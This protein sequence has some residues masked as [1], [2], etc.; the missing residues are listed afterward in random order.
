MSTDLIAL[1]PDPLWNILLRF[2]ITLVVLFIV[3]RLIYFRYS[4]NEGNVFSFFLMGVMIFLVCV[5]LK[6]V[7]IQ[8]GMAL[9]LFA[10]FSI[11]RFRSRNLSLRAMTYFFT[12]IGVSVINSMAT[13]PKPVR[14]TIL[15]NSIIILTLIILEFFF[16]KKTLINHT[17]IYDKLELLNPDKMQEL[18][19]DISIRT[20]KKIEKIEINKMDLIKGNAELEVF[21]R[22]TNAGTE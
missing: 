16:H 3:I 20:G 14:G 22:N 21:F 17:L 9:G 15:I 2:L 6:S 4:K 13:F 11:L 19:N 12:V 1:G 8:L 7:E 5:L 18:L 10:I